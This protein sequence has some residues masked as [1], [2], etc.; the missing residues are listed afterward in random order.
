MKGFTEK[1][2]FI[3]YWLE[4]KLVIKTMNKSLKFVT[5]L[6]W[7][8]FKDYRD[9]YLNCD[10]LFLADLFEKIRDKRWKNYV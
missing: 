3:V 8:K 10:V 9:V 2:Y 6:G 4:K 5:N 1:T 7:K